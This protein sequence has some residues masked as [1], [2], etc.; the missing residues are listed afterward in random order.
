MSKYSAELLAGRRH[1]IDV[2]A[3]P[4]DV[5]RRIKQATPEELESPLPDRWLQQHSQARMHQRVEESHA[6]AHRKR[7]RRAR[8]RALAARQ[9]R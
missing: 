3:Y 2:Q 9:L 7:I 4:E 6:V 5:L 1:S 8:R